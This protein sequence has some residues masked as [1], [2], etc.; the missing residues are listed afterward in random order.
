[1]PTCETDTIIETVIQYV[2]YCENK[3]AVMTS[4]KGSLSELKYDVPA[5]LVVFLVALPLCLGIALASGAPLFS[6]LIA[7]IVGGIVVGFLSGSSLSVSG[8]AAGLTAIVVTALGDLGSYNVFLLAVVIAGAIQLILGFAR[9]GIIAYYFPSAVIKG[10][11]AAIGLI[12]ILKQ[13]PHALGFDKDAMG[14]QDF[15]QADGQNTY[16]EIWLAIQHYNIGAVIIA[17]ISVAILLLWERPF[18]KKYKFFELVP[19]ALVVVIAGVAT[20]QLFLAV[21]PDLVLSGD[22]LVTLP[23]AATPKEFFSFF[24]LPDFTAFT[25]PLVYKVAFTLAIVASLESLLSLE[26][27]DKLDPYKRVSPSN[28]E[29]KAQGVG[30]ILS[31]LIGGL[32]VTAVI[33]RSSANVSSGARTKASAIIH[34]VLLLGSTMFIP[35]IL[36]L[37]PLASLAALLILIGYKLAKVALFKQMFKLGWRQFTPFVVTIIVI[38]QTDLLIGITVGLAVGVFYILQDN[39]TTPFLSNTPA[40]IDKKKQLLELSEHVSFLNKASIQQTLIKLPEGTH[41][42]IDGTRTI[43]IDYDVIEVISNFLDTSRS[44]KIE[45]ELKGEALK[46][47]VKGG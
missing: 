28:R 37:I 1:M 32:P 31:G 5:G 45:V 18:L 40:D 12:L 26:A 6:G 33:V 38:L 43:R 41:L 19:G 4:P 47:L 42:V 27:S 20:N 25:N 21:S 13:I 30:N 36:N 29:L 39:Y 2:A 44:K 11:L 46:D 23:I 24:T 14:D 16:T 34:G 10:M 22:H 15:F 7:G 9:A 17:T 8:P 35:G 3:N